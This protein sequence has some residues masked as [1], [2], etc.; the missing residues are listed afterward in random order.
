M[1][2]TLDPPETERRYLFKNPEKLEWNTALNATH[3]I[4]GGKPC[5]FI[6]ILPKVIPCGYHSPTSPSHSGLA[7]LNSLCETSLNTYC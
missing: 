2:A 3:S 5:S 6:H 4:K 7:V 1:K